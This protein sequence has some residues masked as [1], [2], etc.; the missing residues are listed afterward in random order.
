MALPACFRACGYIAKALQQTSKGIRPVRGRAMDCTAPAVLAGPPPRNPPDSSGHC[1]PVSSPHPIHTS[2]TPQRRACSAACRA[3]PAT[4][5]FSL[6]SQHPH[7]LPYSPPPTLPP[8]PLTFRIPC[9]MRGQAS[10]LPFWPLLPQLSRALSR[11]WQV[12]VVAGRAS[13]SARQR[14][15]CRSPEG[16]E[17]G[18][19]QCCARGAKEG[20]MW[21][22]SVP[23]LF[24]CTSSPAS[25]TQTLQHRRHHH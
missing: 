1:H 25:R 7:P 16:M 8:Q 18:G 12:K 5:T 14:S 21:K 3:Q 11:S 10:R 9:T 17:G 19:K 4:L 2:L 13:H 23:R 22:R 20:N 6:A 15:G 24:V